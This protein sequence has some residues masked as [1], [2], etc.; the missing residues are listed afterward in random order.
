MMRYICCALNTILGNERNNKVDW[1]SNL[2]L[3]YKHI[4]QEVRDCEVPPVGQQ[5]SPP[6]LKAPPFHHGQ[7]ASAADD[8]SQDVNHGEFAHSLVFV[9]TKDFPKIS[10]HKGSRCGLSQ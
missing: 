4:Q 5:L 8:I 2:N 3:F 6:C 10:L 9:C 7:R 1:P